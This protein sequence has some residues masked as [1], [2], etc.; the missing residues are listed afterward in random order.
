MQV[1]TIRQEHY[2][3][4]T[5]VKVRMMSDSDI[6]T[7]YDKNVKGLKE[8]ALSSSN[9]YLNIKIDDGVISGVEIGGLPNKNSGY[10]PIGG[11]E[12][13]VKFFGN[14]GKKHFKDRIRIV[15]LD[16]YAYNT[17][18]SSDAVVRLLYKTYPMV[19]KKIDEVF[20]V[21]KKRGL[22]SGKFNPIECHAIKEVNW[23]EI[24]KT[25]LRRRRSDLR[26]KDFADWFDANSRLAKKNVYQTISEIGVAAYIE[27][28]KIGT[29]ETEFDDELATSMGCLSQ[30]IYLL[31]AIERRFRIGV[32][33]TKNI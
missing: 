30:M 11:V 9:C 4:T 1:G 2:Y 19:T 15:L 20:T 33:S 25:V 10:F 32:F 29:S 17:D 13:T 26:A 16:G 31:E 28:L 24:E 12:D 22:K 27:S 7:Y 3:H 14:R 8:T 23:P 5:N 21:I 6:A 18:Y